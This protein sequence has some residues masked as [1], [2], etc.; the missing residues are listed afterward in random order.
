MHNKEKDQL[1]YEFLESNI[2]EITEKWLAG[3]EHVKGSLY[4]NDACKEIEQLLREQNNFTNKTVNIALLGDEG[5]Y[6]K[7]ER[8][9]GLTVAHSRI[10][11]GTPI[12]QV[13]AALSKARKSYWAF[14]ERYID[15][16][17]TGITKEDVLRWSEIIFET[18]EKLVQK[19]TEF[20]HVLTKGRLEAQQNLINDLGSPVIPIIDDIGVLPLVGDIDT[21][22]AKK[23]LE[24][25]PQKC[26]TF[27]IEHL[28]IDLSGVPVV[29]TMVAQQL[30]LITNTL[31][32][33][34]I[35]ATISGIRPEVA[36]TSIQLGLDFSRLKTFST[37]KQ[38]LQKSGV[39]L[40]QN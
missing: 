5:S 15:E 4:S 29:D 22:R 16:N 14:V 9:W 20:Y 34:G 24:L 39:D 7:H 38:A 3:R 23:L 13:L 36:Q 8:E 11:S 40:K 37:L 28:F 6:K 18:F 31:E 19:F 10:E 2:T 35:N 30:F 32:I 26:V 25:I 21:D 27:K 33:L 12:H 1:L 17:E